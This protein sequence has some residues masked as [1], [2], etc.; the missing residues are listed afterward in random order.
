MASLG[1]DT[2]IDYTN[3]DF[4]KTANGHDILYD[5]VMTTTTARCRK[6]LKPG[7]VFVNNSRL[8]QIQHAD[9]LLL[10]DLTEQGQLRPVIDRN[11][12]GRCGFSFS[13]GRWCGLRRRGGRR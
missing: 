1:A 2:V 8:P 10:K 5:A 4:T 12:L 11:E 6:I 9:L 3:E 7:G 13:D